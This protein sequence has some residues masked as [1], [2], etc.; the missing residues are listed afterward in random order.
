MTRMGSSAKLKDL[1]LLLKLRNKSWPPYVR[2]SRSQSKAEK[3]QKLTLAERPGIFS[4]TLQCFR[5]INKKLSISFTLFQMVDDIST[6]CQFATTQN[7]LH[8]QSRQACRL[9]WSA[10]ALASSA[11]SAKP[12]MG[13]TFVA[14]ATPCVVQKL[15][16]VHNGKWASSSKC[17]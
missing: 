15:W 2:H 12:R 7:R 1:S 9:N 14:S 17:A 11:C 10:P 3:R 4:E 5:S 6:S 8:L 16:W 13:C